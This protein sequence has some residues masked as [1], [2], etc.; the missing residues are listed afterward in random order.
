MT[1]RSEAY[2]GCNKN[3][4]D[5][6]IVHAGHRIASLSLR[7]ADLANHLRNANPC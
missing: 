7:N 3:F 6:S 5:E 1:P 4:Q 2:I